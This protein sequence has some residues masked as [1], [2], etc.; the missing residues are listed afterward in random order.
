ML[1]P[2]PMRWKRNDMTGD[3]KYEQNIIPCVMI[4]LT[5]PVRIDLS[6]FFVLV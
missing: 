5:P 1:S 3:D 2:L 6:E 4:A